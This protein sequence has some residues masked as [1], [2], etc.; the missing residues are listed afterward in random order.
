MNEYRSHQSPGLATID[1]QVRL[2]AE[3]HQRRIGRTS[4]ERHEDE[5]EDIERE[6]EIREEDSAAPQLMQKLEIALFDHLLQLTP[7]S[8]RLAAFSQ[9]LWQRFWHSRVHPA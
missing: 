1:F 4:G 9:F 8:G 3:S 5:D 7:T 6:Q 2:H